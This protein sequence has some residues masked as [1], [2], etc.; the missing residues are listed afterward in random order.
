MKAKGRFARQ[1]L[2]TAAIVALV[3]PLAL[4]LVHTNSVNA[5]VISE[6]IFGETNQPSAD[7]QLLLESDNL[8]FDSN[9]ELV[10]AT[11]NVQIAYGRT[12]LV[13]DRV[14]YN[15]QSG[16]VTAFGNVEIIEPGGNKIF[17]HEI[18]VTDDFSDGFVSA[19]NVQTADNTRIA[20]E[21]ASR[22]DGTLTQFN[23]GVYTACEQCKEDP[24]KPPFWQIRAK[25][26]VVDGDTK[27]VEYEDATFEIFGKPFLKLPYFSHADPSIKRKSGLLLPTMSNSNLLGFGYRQGYFFNLAPDYD[28]TAWGTYYTRQGFLGEAEWRQRLANGEYSIHYAGIDQQEKEAFSAGTVDATKDER[29]A[30]ITSGRFEINPRWDFGWNAL[31]QSD[32]NFAR[33][34]NLKNYDQR[35]VTNE[36]YLTGLGEKNYFK[37]AAQDFLVQSNERDAL[38]FAKFPTAFTGNQHATEQQALVLPVMDY[39]AVS[40]E[41]F[42][43]G[44]LSLDVNVTSIQRDAPDV[45]NFDG[46]AAS[47]A[48]NER[49]A[50][51]PGTSTRASA[52]LEW[53]GSTITDGGFVATTA[54]S[55]QGDAI[56]QNHDDLAS[57]GNP[58]TNNRSIYRYMPAAEFEVRLP[59]IAYDGTTT[60]IFEPIAQIIARSNETHIG[61]IANEDA[62]SLVFDTSNLFSRNKFSGYD[63]VEGGTRANLGFRFSSTFENGSSINI[64]AGQSFHLAGKN[65]FANTDDLTNT[66][67]ESGLE[68]DRSDFVASLQLDTG[69]GFALGTGFRLDEQDF[70]VRRAEVTGR[71]IQQ[72]YSVAASYAFTQAQPNYRFERDRHE[73]SV[74]GSVKLDENWRAFGSSAYDVVENSFVRNAAG[75]AYDDSCF[76]FSVAY[77]HENPKFSSGTDE[78]KINFS[79][80]LRTIGGFN[81]SV[82]FEEDES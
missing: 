30:L 82:S 3:S 27:T 4:G 25:K 14:E 58:L 55:V 34:Y 41:A 23:N 76:S 17:A 13:A 38:N 47:I 49:F 16:R 19:L 56:Q 32:E 67:E 12:T 31:F 8:E 39:N 20:A 81:R 6:N 21:S 66:G 69:D 9:R 5:Q 46:T 73:V 68:T 33:S 7:E 71:V 72:D 36:V 51:L 48:A 57:F 54:L 37:V 78:H 77:S 50:G 80:G 64:M 65:S 74:S 53:K 52:L 60:H 61:E 35:D 2:I 40:G 18:D 75:I 70:S 43:N 59:L 22:K 15:Q 42:E 45:A 26:V 79:L 28:V 1:P 44:Q 10:I 11:G 29:H 62:Q 24:T 63:R